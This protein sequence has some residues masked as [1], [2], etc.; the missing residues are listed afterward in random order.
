M[1]NMVYVEGGTFTMGATSEQK[2]P[3]DDE[4]PTHR[5]SLS[6]FYIGKYE[7]TQ[8]LWKAVMGSN[9]SH[10]KGDNLPVE[11]V[12]WNDCQTFLRKLNAM[13]GKNFRLPTEAEWEYAARGGN[14]S[15]GY[16]YSGSKK[17]DDVAWYNNNS[18]GET[19]PVGT[20][21]PNELGIYDMSG[22]VWEWC[23]D[24]YGDYHGYSQT[25]PTGPSCGA[26]R[27]YRGGSWGS[28]A[29]LCRVA[30]RDNYTPGSR[31]NG[32]GLR[33]ALSQ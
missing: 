1:R 31:G 4:K 5:V 2:K 9:P 22:N 23:Q 13:T 12:S 33:L 15:R 25:N 6:S 29:W 18:G 28:G 3:D 30:F 32:L 24:W 17:I 11:N 26:N 7:V 16:Q 14:L 21:A 10:W 8:A 19:H 20:K 27:V